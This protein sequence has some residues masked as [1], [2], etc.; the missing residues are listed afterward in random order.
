MATL[1]AWSSKVAFAAVIVAAALVAPASTFASGNPRIQ[2]KSPLAG[3]VFEP[4][5]AVLVSV[6]VA[7]R[8]AAGFIVAGASDAGIIQGTGF[9]GSS[10]QARFSI[11]ADFA[12]PLTITPFV[13]D[14]HGNSIAGTSVTIVVRPTGS[15]SRLNVVQAT[16]F[17]NGPQATANLDVV[18]EYPNHVEH[19]LTSGDAGTKYRS[20]DT[21]V[22]EV[23]AGGRA[24][25][26]GP[27]TA[28]VIIKNGGLKAFAMF[29]VGDPS[30]PLA[31]VDVTDQLKIERLP[32]QISAVD[33][34]TNRYTQTLRISNAKSMPILGRLYIVVSNL[35][36]KAVV[37]DAG[38]TKHVE[39]IG[40]LYFWPQL[41]DGLTLRPGQHVS[42]DLQLWV[43]ANTGVDY[44]VRVFRTSV[45]P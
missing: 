45:E 26:V 32:P 2:I 41:P 6:T 36:A 28:V 3:Q 17:L 38:R 20:S 44:T 35:P 37:T 23:D 33:P 15:P 19:D 42:A 10:Y 22:I 24:R 12:G 8:A 21:R 29:W 40:S 16:F 14:A 11:P 7:V 18:G 34:F 43:P 4:G 30:H 31:P 9:D 25:A 27:G 13:M 5:Q 39:P 1:P